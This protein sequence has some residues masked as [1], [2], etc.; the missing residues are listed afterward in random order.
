M[1]I[2]IYGLSK[3]GTSALFYKVKN[4]LPAGTIALFEP[5]SYGRL[6]RV[7]ERFAATL[8][9]RSDLHVLAKVLPLGV[10]PV[11]IRDFGSFERQV[12]IVRDPRDRVVSMLLYWAH[13]ARFAE[14]DN[15][16]AVYL[17][18]LRRKEAE[19][20]SVSLG[21]LAQAFL[22]LDGSDR[23]FSGWVERWGNDVSGA[24][25]FHEERPHVFLFRYEDMVE[26]RFAALES[27]LGIR[28]DGA[29]TVD[30]AFGRVVRTK[31]YGGWRNWFTEA[32]VANFAAAL[33]PYLDH[34]YPAADWCL[35]AAPRIEPEHGSGYV[36]RLLNERRVLAG[37]P[38]LGSKVAG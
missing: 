29:A 13:R 16:A 26:G 20:K 12:L 5:S 11:R 7:R 14:S 1:R 34:Y 38:P 17:D 37:L 25:R 18:L 9:G 2:V 31:S 8:G 33:Q 27:F 19:P 28:L 4:S 24:L 32:D 6:D 23:S 15:D 10:R 21:Q 35:S 22:E 30:P 3:T 36:E